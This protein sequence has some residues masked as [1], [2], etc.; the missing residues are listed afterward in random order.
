M[1]VTL[2]FMVKSIKIQKQIHNIIY[3]LLSVSITYVYLG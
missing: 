1:H 2:F 3:E